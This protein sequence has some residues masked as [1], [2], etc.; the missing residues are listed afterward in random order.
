MLVASFRDIG[1]RLSPVALL[2]ICLYPWF[3][4]SMMSMLY[5]LDH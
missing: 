1:E 5:L 3:V 2:M 4:I